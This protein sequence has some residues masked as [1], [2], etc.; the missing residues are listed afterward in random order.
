MR[1]EDQDELAEHMMLGPVGGRVAALAGASLGSLW[2]LHCSHK[3]EERVASPTMHRFAW[4]LKAAEEQQ[5]LPRVYFIIRFATSTLIQ[6]F[7]KPTNK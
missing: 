6:T 1:L 4:T 5:S 2:L 3:Q 7:R